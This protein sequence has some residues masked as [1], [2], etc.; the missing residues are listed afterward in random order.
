MK[1]AN[2]HVR[3]PLFQA[4]DV[5]GRARAFWSAPSR[6]QDRNEETTLTGGIVR[7]LHDGRHVISGYNLFPVG[8]TV[9]G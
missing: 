2:K 6:Y 4:F 7:L 1:H 8:K 9:P 5:Q 3:L